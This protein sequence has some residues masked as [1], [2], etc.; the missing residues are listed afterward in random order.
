MTNI[1]L[2][3]WFLQATRSVHGNR[4]SV[5]M[6]GQKNARKILAGCGKFDANRKGRDAS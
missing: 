1:A 2:H 4:V 3:A 6:S 5:E